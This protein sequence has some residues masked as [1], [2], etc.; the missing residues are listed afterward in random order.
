M[1]GSGDE[2]ARLALARAVA[3][4]E[5]GRRGAARQELSR[6]IFDDA[7]MM[8]SAARLSFVLRDYRGTMRLLDAAA[9]HGGTEGLQA[10]DDKAELAGRLGWYRE[11]RVAVDAAIGRQR[12]AS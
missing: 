11:A 10:L 8:R 6:A 4:M 3:A 2:D 1:I 7:R 5:E 12:E 9:A